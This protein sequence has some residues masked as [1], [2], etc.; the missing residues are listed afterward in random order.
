MKKRARFEREFLKLAAV[1][2]ACHLKAMGGDVEGGS[3]G[4]LA[5]TCLGIKDYC[6]EMKLLCKE[7]LEGASRESDIPAGSAF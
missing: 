7:V 6:G 2:L 4:D 5:F 3:P 1:A